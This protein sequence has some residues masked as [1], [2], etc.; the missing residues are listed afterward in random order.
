MPTLES[1]SEIKHNI[2]KFTNQINNALTQAY[3]NV[4]IFVP[5]QTVSDEDVAMN[6]GLL[7]QYKSAVVSKNLTLSSRFIMLTR[8]GVGPQ[9]PAS[10]PA[11]AHQNNIF[12]FGLRTDDVG[13]YEIQINNFGSL[14]AENEALN[15]RIASHYLN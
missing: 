10:A 4:T 13:A 2:L 6:I 15:L 12:A 7:E 14:F 3:G 9:A 8:V 11:P 1:K 5:Q